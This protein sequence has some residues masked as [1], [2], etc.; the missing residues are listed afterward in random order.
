MERSICVTDA[1]VAS[2]DELIRRA[3]RKHPR[4]S[5]DLLARADDIRGQL[6]E[7]SD[8]ALEIRDQRA[9]RS[10]HAPDRRVDDLARRARDRRTLSDRET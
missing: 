4:A 2:V 8:R 6:S 9:K 7:A 1:E 3:A 5:A 10:R